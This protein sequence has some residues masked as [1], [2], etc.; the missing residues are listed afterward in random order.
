MYIASKHGLQ[1]LLVMVVT[2]SVAKAKKEN[3]RPEITQKQTFIEYRSN[4]HPLIP[5]TLYS[6]HSIVKPDLT[7]AGP[8]SSTVTTTHWLSSSKTLTCG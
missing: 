2:T 4:Q 7:W 5:D 1:V 8:T 6:T 3:T